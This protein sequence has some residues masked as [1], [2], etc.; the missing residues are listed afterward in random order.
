MEP[1]LSSL[2]FLSR[3]KKKYC[4]FLPTLDSN[5]CLCYSKECPPGH[6]LWTSLSDEGCAHFCLSRPS[7]GPGPWVTGFTLMQHLNAVPSPPLYTSPSIPL[8]HLTHVIIT[9]DLPQLL[10]LTC[11]FMQLQGQKKKKKSQIFL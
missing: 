8:T 5:R 6:S 2:Y 10:K 3:K 4:V 11:S 1:G 9:A 7:S